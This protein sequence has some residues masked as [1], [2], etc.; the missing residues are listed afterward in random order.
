[1]HEE[2]YRERAKSD[3]ASFMY[4]ATTRP[5]K[6]THSCL[7]STGEGWTSDAPSMR[8]MRDGRGRQAM[9]SVACRE[10]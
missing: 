4:T 10:S 5:E 8:G 7:R 1:M 3:C 2:R 9:Q 6:Q